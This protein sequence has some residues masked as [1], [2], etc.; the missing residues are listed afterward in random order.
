M[1]VVEQYFCRSK[2]TGETERKS[3][4]LAAV[5]NVCSEILPFLFVSGEAVARNLPLLKAKVS[6]TLSIARVS[7]VEIILKVSF[8]T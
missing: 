7:N 6:R 8:S 1:N 4:K 3:I 2:Y 5:E